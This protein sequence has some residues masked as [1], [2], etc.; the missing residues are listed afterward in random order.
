M[1][2]FIETCFRPLLQGNDS[3]AAE[4]MLLSVDIGASVPAML[5]EIASIANERYLS[6]ATDI[7]DNAV[8]HL[9]SSGLSDSKSTE[10]D[11]CHALSAVASAAAAIRAVASE[12]KLLPGPASVKKSILDACQSSLRLMPARNEDKPSCWVKAALLL[13]AV[14]IN[15]LVMVYDKTILAGEDI[16]L[17]P[18][19][20]E[21]EPEIGPFVESAG[22]VL[23]QMIEINL[24]APNSQENGVGKLAMSAISLGELCTSLLHHESLLELSRA[25]NKSSPPALSTRVHGLLLW[26]TTWL[27]RG[28]RKGGDAIFWRLHFASQSKTRG[29]VCRTMNGK[30]EQIVT[31][32]FT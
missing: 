24:F 1:D 25:A 3:V 20:G 22:A 12:H 31:E 11:S 9:S 27:G 29:A 19:S 8:K 15:N 10:E 6:S 14:V 18:D 32:R 16:S 21:K 4:A 5:R 26:N 30:V 2:I 17:N 7:L 28:E 23:R 13:E